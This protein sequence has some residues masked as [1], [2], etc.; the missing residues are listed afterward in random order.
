[1]RTIKLWT[2]TVCMAMLTIFSVV[3]PVRSEVYINDVNADIS[4][5]EG[6]S[7]T[8]PFFF[9]F[10]EK[11]TELFMWIETVNPTNKIYFDETGQWRYFSTLA[12][13]RPFLKLPAI[14]TSNPY[15]YLHFPW[16]F[17]D[18]TSGYRSFDLNFCMDENVDG[19]LAQQDPSICTTRRV[20]ILPAADN[21]CTGL[22]VSTNEVTKNLTVGAQEAPTQIAV[23]NSCGPA[24]FTATTDNPSLV[25]LS[26]QSGELT[27]NYNTSTST[28]GTATIKIKIVS[29]KE[30][31]EVTVNYTV[32]AAPCSLT[33]APQQITETAVKGTLKGVNVT[34]NSCS[35]DFAVTDD[36]SWI[37]TTKQSGGIAV[38]LDASALN[39]G[40]YTGK[41]NFTSAAGN[42]SIAVTLTVTK[43]SDAVFAPPFSVGSCTSKSAKFIPS[44]INLNIQQGASLQPI[45]VGVTD[46]CG[47]VISF[48]NATVTSGTSWLGVSPQSGSGQLTV[49]MTN[50]G[51]LPAGTSNVGAVSISPTGYPAI[52]LPVTLNIGGACVASAA[53][54]SPS[55]IAASA[56]TGSNAANATV[57][58]KDNC[59]TSIP[60][61]VTN[62]IQGATAF[63]AAPL[64][65]ATSETGS[66]TVRFN[67]AA[68]AVANYSGS[69]ELNLGNTYGAKSIPVHLNVTAVNTT[70]PTNTTATLLK[71][72]NLIYNSYSP[73]QVSYFY[74]YEN[75]NKGLGNTQPLI[76][77]QM[78]MTAGNGYN[79][80]DMIVK[81]AGVQCELGKPT[82][83]EYKAIKT[84]QMTTAQARSRNIY[85]AL[86][87]DAFETINIKAPNPEGCYYVMV[88][89]ASKVS[90]SKISLKYEDLDSN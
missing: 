55:S 12:E 83:E 10:P 69:I 30:E 76:I 67:A 20:N 47:K 65:G 79:D 77:S 33:V 27:I 35:V 1:M 26:I 86:S 28:A 19:M 40:S 88:I 4:I 72:Y 54:I 43:G 22:T 80:I 46:N 64:T 18:N 41:I 61:A 38:T 29:G 70:S 39:V 25:S 85:S 73:G 57:S 23:T 34:V 48:T 90:E 89:N 58:I 81:Y 71:N 42:A 44:S 7:L 56:T 62:V 16:P 68:L 9:I 8:I 2:L 51:S 52:T 11:P 50:T 84:G 78:D 36:Q 53:I 6:A 45:D 15:K 17:T 24:T 66:L 5:Q 14:D 32:A 3:S 87:S 37:T 21:N 63:I 59:G 60:Y 82:I 74:F 75:S 31:K 49:T 13:I